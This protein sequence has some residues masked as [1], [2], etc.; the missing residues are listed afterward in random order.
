[1]NKRTN[2]ET[3]EWT[4]RSRTQHSP[5]EDCLQTALSSSPKNSKTK[6]W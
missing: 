6:I 2:G 1:M 5:S 3:D 4:D